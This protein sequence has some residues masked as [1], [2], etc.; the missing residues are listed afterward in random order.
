MKNLYLTLAA[1]FLTAGV[2]AQLSF[3]N[4]TIMLN[5]TFNSGGCIGIADMNGDGLDDIVH[6]NESRRAM[7]EYQN[8]DGSFTLYDYGNVSGSNQWGMCLGDVDNNGHNDI[9][10]GGSYDGVHLV[11]IDSPGQSELLS[12]PF[13]SMFMQA[14]NMADINNDGWL[15]IFACHDEAESRIWGNDGAGV[16]VAANEWIDATTT[17]ASDNSGNYGSVWTDINNDGHIDFYIAKCRQGVNNPSDPRRINM[18]FINDGNNNYIES[19]AARGVASNYQSWTADFADIDNDGDMD[20]FL[21]NHDFTMQLFEND[22]NGYFTDITEGSGLEVEGFI[23]QGL[24][25]DFDNDGFV[26]VIYAGGSHGFRKG[27]GDGTFTTINSLFPYGDT[28]HSFAVGDLN[29]DGFLDVYSSYGNNYVTPDFSNSDVLWLN[30]GNA[31]NYMALNLIGTESNKNAI[32]ARVEIYGPW[33]VQ[34]R[35][36]RS[37]ESYGINNSFQIHFGLGAETTIDEVVIKWPSG[38]TESFE[39]VAANQT[40]TVIE[41]TCISQPATIVADGP[42]IICAGT[43][44]TLT[45]NEGE[46]YLWSNGATTQSIE[47]AEAGPISVTVFT[48]AG[49]FGNSPTVNISFEPDETPVVSV[50]GV[51]EFCEGES[52]ILTSSEA[53]TYEWSNNAQTQSIEVTE[54]GT[55]SVTVEGVCQDFTSEMIS[56]NVIAAPEAPLAEGDVIPAPGIATLTAVGDN[57]RWY[58]MPVG[59]E[60]LEEGSVYAPFISQTTPFYVEEA[61]LTGGEIYF[62]GKEDNSGS[63]AFHNNSTYFQIF[64]VY[65]EMILKSVKVYANGSGN[66]TIRVTG[67]NNTPIIAEGTF[68]VPDGESIVELNFT[69]PAGDDLEIKTTGNPQLYR[70]ANNSGVS[71]PYLLGDMGAITSTNIEGSNQ[72]LYYYFFYNWE[73]ER[74]ITGC[75]SERT[76]ALAVIDTTV[77]LDDLNKHDEVSVFPVPATENLNVLFHFNGN[78]N[79]QVLDVT[80]KQVYTNGGVASEG[81]IHTINVKSL[82]SGL[83]FVKIISGDKAITRK[84]VVR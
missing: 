20:L 28:M 30:N 27:N 46:S 22:G 11:M 32:G 17:P 66:R 13:G 63:G 72:F 78:Y 2:S 70:N 81:Q 39:D 36:V 55:Y 7:I 62:G 31:N 84:V 15:D 61:E 12:L 41:N 14:C 9:F 58:D 80:G 82:H 45:A 83:Y 74:P 18:M 40:L 6:L 35:E 25:K 3:S 50:D 1:A 47:V 4:A 10:S 16:L 26:D 64:D 67:P 69:I 60:I 34:V 5:Q 51:L 59:G 19:A 49:C 77:G 53:E 29:N 42:T 23:L 33:G 44:L 37:G 73:V 57:L 56:V 24:M 43:T 71:Y 75:V 8:P 48:G 54:S 68:N 38:I 21:T 52:V 76:E 65:E 79:L